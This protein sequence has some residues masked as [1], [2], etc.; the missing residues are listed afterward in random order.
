VWVTPV[1]RALI[2][3]EPGEPGGA[4]AAEQRLSPQR[5][6][7]LY[8]R[9]SGDVLAFLCSLTRNRERADDLLQA[10]FGRLAEKGHTAR[11]ASIRGW[12]LRVAHSEAM[13]AARRDGVARRGLGIIAPLA[14]LED[15]AAPWS[16]LVTAEDAARVRAALAEL[17]AEQRRVVE[18]RIHGEKTFAAIAA[19]EGVPIGTVITRMRL[20]LA[21]LQARLRA[22]DLPE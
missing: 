21:K 6:R 2:E 22:E 10:T 5:V 9:W 20:A 3:P 8:E 11:P 1:E 17:P 15:D 13:Q 18:E 12:L 4:T 19:A 16:P 14:R 7:E